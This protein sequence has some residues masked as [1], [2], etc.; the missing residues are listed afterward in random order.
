[1]EKLKK[2]RNF[3]GMQFVLSN[4][5][6]DTLLY[7]FREYIEFYKNH[8]ASE[9]F[10]NCIQHVVDCLA[11]LSY[12]EEYTEDVHVMLGFRELEI[13]MDVIIDML[14]QGK[15]PEINFEERLA[16]PN[17]KKWVTREGDK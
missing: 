11:N 8:G 12:F 10:L 16:N 9:N 5:E 6:Y 4:I 1:M 7:H 2:A 14:P 15:D 3:D 17:T 13:F